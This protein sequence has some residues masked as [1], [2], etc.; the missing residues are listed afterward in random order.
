MKKLRLKD[1]N[2]PKVILPQN[3]RLV[4]WTQNNLAS[5]LCL[6]SALWSLP[7]G[8]EAGDA[9]ETVWWEAG[10]E[11]G[12]SKEV[13]GDGVEAGASWDVGVWVGWREGPMGG[14]SKGEI[15]CIT[16]FSFPAH[17]FQKLSFSLKE[18]QVRDSLG[19][20]I[21]KNGKSELFLSSSSHLVRK[22]E[23]KIFCTVR[24]SA[25]TFR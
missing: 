12:A 1:I 6:T 22:V 21:S 16:W 20:G 24:W 4:I 14:D 17:Q 2:L 11:G 13:W 8:W 19:I 7:G 18:S 5:A 23:G 3:S 25:S 10:T 15:S 9:E